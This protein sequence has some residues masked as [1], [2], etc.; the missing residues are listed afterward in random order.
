M[1][2]IQLA[3]AGVVRGTVV[4]HDSPLPGATV[5]LESS[6]ARLKKTSDAEGHFEFFNVP[7]GEYE[8]T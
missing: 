3:T 6:S 7:P 4:L 1:I 2:Q 8:L 5:T